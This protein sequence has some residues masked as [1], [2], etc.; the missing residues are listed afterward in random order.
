MLRAAQDGAVLSRR[1]LELE[2]RV[3][4]IVVRETFQYQLELAAL[5]SALFR[6][7]ALPFVRLGHTLESVGG[8]EAPEE[9]AMD[10]P[11]S[12][13]RVQ[14]ERRVSAVV[15]NFPERRVVNR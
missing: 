7:Y 13:R 11:V 9:P 6:L 5:L 15:I 8:I 12:G 1:L 10:K 4:N 2:M 3:A 14:A